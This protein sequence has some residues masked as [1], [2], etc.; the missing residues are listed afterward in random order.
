MVPL[1]SQKHT[2]EDMLAFFL[3]EKSE[4]M[5][6]TYEKNERGM[7]SFHSRGKKCSFHIIDKQVLIYLSHSHVVSRKSTLVSTI[8]QFK[9]H[10]DID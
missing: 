10:S 2:K 3:H 1:F 7:I 6:L 9:I 8:N 5:L 4:I